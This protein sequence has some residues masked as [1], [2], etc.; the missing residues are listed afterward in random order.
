MACKQEQKKSKARNNFT[1]LKH[2]RFFSEANCKKPTK[3]DI[4]KLSINS[5]IRYIIISAC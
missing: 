2:K 3:V 4:T 5:T 1:K